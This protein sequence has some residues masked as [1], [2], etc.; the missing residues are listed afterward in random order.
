M[1][2][3]RRNEVPV[4][5]DAAELE[6]NVADG[7]VP[8]EQSDESAPAG[9]DRSAGP[10]D[11]TEVPEDGLMRIDLGSML[12]PG[13]EGMELRLD[14]DEA[15]QNVVACTLVSGESAMQMM[16]F[17]APRTDGIWDDVR[18]EI[19]GNLASQGPVEE[20]KGTFGLELLATLPVAG[21]QGQQG[22][23]PVRFVGV[24]GPRWF[25]RGLFSGPAAR[26]AAA[27]E[28][29]EAIFR[30]TVVVRGTDPMAPGDLLPL[31]VPVV[32]D[33]MTEVEAP[34][35]RKPLLPPERGPEITEIR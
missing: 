27:S 11:V 17:A 30:S 22:L 21:P 24:D 1:F 28:P 14:I 32:E 35:E 19:R 34:D 15:S 12:V 31:R 7:R 29:L 20:A 16:A 8:D 26:N 23:Q 13:I 2:R 4:E 6:E 10:F 18:A 5:V 33:G 9:A 25:L 3:R